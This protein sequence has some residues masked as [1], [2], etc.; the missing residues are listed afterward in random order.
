MESN[1]YV[2]FCYVNVTDIY[3]GVSYAQTTVI[4]ES[5]NNLT[6]V[7]NAAK[8]QLADAL[9]SGNNNQVAQ[10]VGAVS[11]S[12]N[13]KNCTV[14]KSC[15]LLNRNPCSLTANTCGS[16]YDGYT[17]V[18]GDSN[19][20][21]SSTRAIAADLKDMNNQASADVAECSSDSDCASKFG[22]C[23]SGICIPFPKTC[24]NNCG[25]HGICHY[26]NSLN[27]PIVQ[28]DATN[29]YCH[30][31][32]EC[33][34][35]YYGKDCNL[36]YND[37]NAK[38]SIRESLCRSLY[39]TVSTQDIG[40]TGTL[41]SRIASIIN[42]FEDITEISPVALTQCTDTLISTIQLGFNIIRSSSQSV[43]L[44]CV[45]AFNLVCYIFFLNNQIFPIL[46]LI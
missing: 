33:Y 16:C 28:C 9:D 13:V 24:S 27:Q 45:N 26:Y 43:Q 23:D 32:C 15:H 46:L 20:L 6:E 29:S 8:K 40:D 18:L 31:T 30:A 12:L 2:V 4:V 37:F 36:E 14:P 10:I 3:G 22:S 25:D 1:G 11:T 35:G 39:S 41:V 17:G 19:T 44:I 38:L 42:I 5:S 21:C 7:Q 34:D